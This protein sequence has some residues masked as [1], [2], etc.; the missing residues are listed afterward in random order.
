[1][2]DVPRRDENGI[3]SACC[4]GSYLDGE[5]AGRK[6]GYREG[7]RAG[8]E[9]LGREEA[10]AFGP[11]VRQLATNTTQAHRALVQRNEGWQVP[12][13]ARQGPELPF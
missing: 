12:E 7:W 10:E 11:Y 6:A 3:P 8:R 4:W 1:M 2:A 5:A 13:W 9:A